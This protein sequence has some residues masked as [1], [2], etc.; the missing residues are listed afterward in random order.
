[1]AR[2][3]RH[4]IESQLDPVTVAFNYQGGF[5]V[6]RLTKAKRKGKLD[7]LKALAAET[8]PWPCAGPGCTR[9]VRWEPEKDPRRRRF[10]KYCSA[11]CRHRSSLQR[12]ARRQRKLD[13]AAWR[14]RQAAARERFKAKL[15]RNPELYERARAREREWRRVW[16]RSEKRRAWREAYRQRARQREREAYRQLT[17]DQKTR[18]AERQREWYRRLTPEQIARR[19]RATWEYLRKWRQTPEGRARYN[20]ANRRSYAKR[21]ARVEAELKGGGR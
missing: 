21:K 12:W 5:G 14:A 17:A 15:R 16:R 20:A 3:A 7:E 13:L 9:M 2:P 18:R 19:R 6:D 11:R 8:P 1:M 4:F 10:R